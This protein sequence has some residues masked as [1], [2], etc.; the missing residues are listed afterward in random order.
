M[1]S[2]THI[3]VP[4]RRY[5][6]VGWE[7][8]SDRYQGFYSLPENTLDYIVLG[9][10]QTYQSTNPMQIYAESGIT[11]YNLGNSCQAK[12]LSYYWLREA[13]KTQSPKYLFIDVNSLIY[14]ENDTYDEWRLLGLMGMKPSLLKL[15]AIYKVSTSDD[16]LYS[17]LFPLYKFHTRWQELY[18]NDFSSKTLNDY[19]LKGASLFF[20][21]NN[22]LLGNMRN[23]QTVN[24]YHLSE[25]FET[26][27]SAHFLGYTINSDEALY[28]E[29]IRDFCTE[30]EITLVPTKFPTANWDSERQ[31]LVDNYISQLGLTVLDLNS[32]VAFNWQTD[33]GDGGSHTNFKGAAKTSHFLADYMMSQGDLTDHRQDPLYAYWNSDLE[34]YSAWEQTQ[35]TTDAQKAYRYL[36]I[37]N[38]YKEEILCVISVRT[39]AVSA[40]NSTLDT[41]MKRLGVHS[42]FDQSKAQMSFIGILDG[43]IS[44]F[45]QWDHQ[46]M[47]LE[48]S[49][50]DS[51][52][53]EHTINTTSAGYGYGD[54]SIIYIDGQ[55][56]SLNG[57]GINL[58]A[59]DKQNGEVLSTCSINTGDEELTFMEKSFSEELLYQESASCQLL[60]DGTYSITPAACTSP[61]EN[62]EK[63]EDRLFKIQHVGDGFYTIQ[64]L[65]E[66]QYVSSGIGGVLPSPGIVPPSISVL[67]SQK[68]FIMPESNG[69]Y[70][71]V[72]LANGYCLTYDPE[73]TALPSNICLNDSNENET[74]QFYFNKI[75]GTP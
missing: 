6:V 59:I 15:E 24:Y 62:A 52:D 48:S 9:T 1:A 53:R 25:N 34:N 69:S 27:N 72:S 36:E 10:S 5:S 16:T 50:R 61:N 35:L 56:Y 20:H 54:V 11:G 7:G 31:A 64:L 19:W 2:V 60:D 28:F 38:S 4:E 44:K 68:W 41:L 58:V 33:S 46:R 39:D 43:G 74:Q 21:E 14:D 65:P 66:N 63:M 55:E 13:C 49:F 45:E 3:M 71:I 67:A 23:D 42:S 37:L 47:W 51:A 57:P 40:W 30:N 26:Q 18:P 22:S 17:S 12:V 32:E 73:N 29:K 70:R 75:A 8:E